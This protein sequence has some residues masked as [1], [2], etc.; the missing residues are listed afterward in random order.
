[1][2]ASDA[3]KAVQLTAEETELEEEEQQALIKKNKFPWHSKFGIRRNIRSLETE[4][5]NFRGLNPV[6]IFI[7]GPPASGK[8]FY[9]ME[10]AKYY[11]IPRV[12]VKQL[13]EE[14]M[15]RA[16]IDEEA[17][18]EDKLTN[19]CRTKIEEIKAAMEEAINEKRAEQEEPEQGWP[20]IVI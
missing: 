6:K 7:T 1:M 8:T 18:G 2:K 15:R 16:A 5:N 10:L 13:V 3:F 9:S 17:A 20:E 12:H 11:N 4:F 19:D 14:V